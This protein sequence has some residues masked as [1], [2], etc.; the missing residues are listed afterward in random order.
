MKAAVAALDMNGIWT[1][2]GSI[3][4]KNT[5]SLKLCETCGLR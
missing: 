5:A 3:V 2:Q 4:P 1:L